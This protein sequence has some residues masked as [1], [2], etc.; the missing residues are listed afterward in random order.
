[1]SSGHF[2]IAGIIGDGLA[3]DVSEHVD[4]FHHS[5]GDNRSGRVRN[6]AA[7]GRQARLGAEGRDG[8]NK[9][10]KDNGVASGSREFGRDRFYHN[11]ESYRLLLGPVE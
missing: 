8:E 4:Y 11:L 1:L 10:E 2:E 7:D 3:T 5:S 9:T 6:D